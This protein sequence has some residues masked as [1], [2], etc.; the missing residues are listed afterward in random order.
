MVTAFGAGGNMAS[1]ANREKS[2]HFTFG[3][4]IVLFTGL[5]VF[6][7]LKASQKSAGRQHWAPALAV[8]LGSVLIMLDPTRH[9]L[10]DHGGVWFSESS[11]SM[12]SDYPQLSPI[13]RFCQIA[14]ILGLALLM[15]GV[16]WFSGIFEKLL[17]H[18][19]G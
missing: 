15:T 12:Y 10:L 8:A 1:D 14:T 4:D 3:A 11:L 19:A 16:I 17:R 18:F 5:T 6:M 2:H 7:V 13:G 9:V